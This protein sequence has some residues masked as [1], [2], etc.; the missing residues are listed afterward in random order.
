ML[1]HS[2]MYHTIFWY[3]YIQ[4]ESILSAQ[5]LGSFMTLGS[6]PYLEK[7]VDLHPLLRVTCLLPKHLISDGS[8][9]QY[10]L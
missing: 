3:I 2:G 1:P 9:I 7:P 5:Y 6:F 10:A 4:M 8:G